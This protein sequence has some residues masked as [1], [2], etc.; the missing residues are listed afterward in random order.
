VLRPVA[1][2]CWDLEPA[3]AIAQQ[4]ELAR[5]LKFVP[6]TRPIRTLAGIDVSVKAGRALAAVVL[7][8][9]PSLKEMERRTTMLPVSYPYIPGLLTYREAPAAL[10]ALAALECEPD[11]LMFDGQG[12]A[13][14]RRMGLASHLGLILDRP[15]IGC[16]KSRLCGAA[17][18]PGTDRGSHCPLVEHGE[19]VGAAVRTRT[20]VRPVYV[21]A[22]HLIDLETAISVVLDACRGY[23]RPEPTRLAHRL[24]TCWVEE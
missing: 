7:L 21:S 16:A 10:E 1:A 22:G 24:S 17:E 8:A 11:L 13:H 20:R 18:N 3:R 15:S 2:Q 4:R 9:Y 5:Q 19:V 12:Y 23:R 14:P 6:L